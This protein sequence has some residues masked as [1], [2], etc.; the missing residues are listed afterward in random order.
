MNRLFISC[1]WGTTSFRLRLVDR[2]SGSIV[3]SY[4]NSEGVKKLHFQLEKSASIEER[5]RWFGLTLNQG[6]EALL[7]QTSVSSEQIASVVIS[8]MA[9]A[10][11]GWK[12]LPYEETPIDLHSARLSYEVLE[13]RCEQL[14]HSPI[15]LLSGLSTQWDVIRGEETLLLGLVEQGALGPG[16]SLVVLPGTHSKHVTIEAGVVTKFRT[17]MTGELFELLASHSIL[18]DSVATEAVLDKLASHELPPAFIEGL[19]AVSEMGLGEVYFQVRARGLLNE[20]WSLSAGRLFLSGCLI[21]GELQ[22]LVGRSGSTIIAAAE[23]LRSCYR[24][25]CLYLGAP[26]VGLTVIEDGAMERLVVDGHLAF[27]RKQGQGSACL[28]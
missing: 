20:Q 11:I 26:A 22:S 18:R 12:E 25:A 15:C 5:A 3:A 21:G 1:D 8:G 19:E 24:N 7:G 6:L 27:L 16:E 23:P 13:Y 28:I 9:S 14:P 17:F 4:A 2:D 10:S